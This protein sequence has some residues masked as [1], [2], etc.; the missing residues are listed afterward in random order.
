M[1]VVRILEPFVAEMLVIVLLVSLIVASW[2]VTVVGIWVRRKM[3]RHTRN[4]ESLLDV[5]KSYARLTVS[6]ATAT[7]KE[8]EKVGH[9]VHEEVKTALAISQS[10]ER[11]MLKIDSTGEQPKEEPS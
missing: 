9:I 6:Q 10:G 2:T 1:M 8:V 11:P 4:V 7:K 5:T 3:G